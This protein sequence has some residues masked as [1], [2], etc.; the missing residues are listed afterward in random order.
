MEDID[1]K[2][3][4][5]QAEVQRLTQAMNASSIAHEYSP[6]EPV[7]MNT[8]DDLIRY[9]ILRKQ[10]D[11]AEL[12]YEI[13]LDRKLPDQRMTDVRAT[14]IRIKELQ[15]EIKSDEKELNHS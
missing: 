3:E 15:Q 13:L 5:K 6:G 10:R 7:V 2:I 1:K 9:S 11:I 4:E 8:S 12:E 14:E